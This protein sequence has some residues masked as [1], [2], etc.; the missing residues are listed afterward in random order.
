M[1]R[2][3]LLSILTV[4]IVLVVLTP[5]P[6][7]QAIVGQSCGA[8]GVNAISTTGVPVVC[9]G[10]PLVWTNPAASGGG[11][12]S[13]VFGRTGVVSAAAN[14]YNFNQLAGTIASAQF[15][16]QTANFFL[17]APNGSAGNP[18]FRAVVSADIPTLNQSTT[19]TAA[20]LSL[21]SGTATM[22]TAAIASG[23]CATVVTVAAANLT[24]ATGTFSVSFNGDPTAVTGYGVSATGAV[25]TIYSYPTAGNLNFKV[26]NSTASSITPAALTLNWQVTHL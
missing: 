1:K 24:T 3:I 2:L 22:G 16:S 7:Q 4:A 10:N 23:A 15:G 25:L 18:T 17:S 12:V 11:A 13:S 8:P 19:G 21:P 6:A 5:A 9:T 20:G 14:D 26:C